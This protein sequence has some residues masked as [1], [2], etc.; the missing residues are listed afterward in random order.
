MTLPSSIE[1]GISHEFPC[2]YLPEQK[3]KL[4]V[5][6]DARVRTAE[7]YNT[8]LT[9]GF[10]RSGEEIYRPQCSAC[11]ACQSL[12]LPVASFS[13]SPSQKRV[14]KK[15]GQRITLRV[16]Q[17][18]AAEYYP[19]YARYIT[20][21]HRNGS[22]YPPNEEQ[23]RQFVFCS[24]TK[25]YFLEGYIDKQLCLVAVTDDTD[26]ALSAIYTFYDP[27]ISGISLGTWAILQ[28]IKLADELNKQWLYLG[29]QID[30]CPAMNYKQ[31]FCPH[32]RLSGANW[33]NSR[34]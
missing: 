6:T 26:D 27:A 11:N 23:Y 29:Y 19:L 10:R 9:L 24:W 33:Q 3:E 17:T 16:T 25:Q 15:A 2:G 7:H 31:R 28:Q 1:V 20:A 30:A 18:A 32:Q 4:L 21:R 14:A 13:A 8:L 5:I 34:R 12:R 22:M